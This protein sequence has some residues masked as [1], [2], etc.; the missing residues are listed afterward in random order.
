MTDFPLIYRAILDY[1]DVDRVQVSD[2]LIIYLSK[3]FTDEN[4][5]KDRELYFLPIYMCNPRCKIKP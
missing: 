1:Q 5:G 3:D 2:G 4:Y